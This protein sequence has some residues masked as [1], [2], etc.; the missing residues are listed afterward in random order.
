MAD[1]LWLGKQEERFSY[2]RPVKGGS[3]WRVTLPPRTPLIH[4]NRARFL[5]K[6][7][8]FL[9]R[10]YRLI[11]APRKL[12]VF[13][14]NICTRSVASR[15]N[16][17]V[18]RTSNFQGTTIGQIVPRQKHSIV[19][20]T[21]FYCSPL[22]FLPRALIQK[23][24]SSISFVNFSGWKTWKPKCIKWNKTRRETHWIKQPKQ[25]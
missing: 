1:Q 19:F 9:S 23:P 8:V 25:N 4:I 12:D 2:K 24:G 7:R 17:L 16:M 13:E 3:V 20:I 6:Q 5:F 18:L 22:N 21:L 15:A 10:N 11:F 14:T